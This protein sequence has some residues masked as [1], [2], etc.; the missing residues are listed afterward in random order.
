MK[1]LPIQV[2]KKKINKNK[3]IDFKSYIIHIILFIKIL[4]KLNI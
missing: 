1:K 4:F 2:M 3:F